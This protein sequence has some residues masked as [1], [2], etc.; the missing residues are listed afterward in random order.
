MKK[1]FCKVRELPNWSKSLLMAVLLLT[2]YVVIVYFHFTLSEFSTEYPFMY[3]GDPNLGLMTMKISQEKAFQ[4]AASYPNQ[5]TLPSCG[6]TYLLQAFFYGDTILTI[7]ISHDKKPRI[8]AKPPFQFS[9][10]ATLKILLT[11]ERN[12]L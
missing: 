3:G 12:R 2:T 11:L 7:A 6:F 4:F 8:R 10:K 1:L 5:H 9:L